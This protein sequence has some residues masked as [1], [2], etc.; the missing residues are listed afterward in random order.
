MIP[1]F[2]IIRNVDRSN[3]SILIF[4]PDVQFI[5]KVRTFIKDR[6]MIDNEFFFHRLSMEK[7]VTEKDIFHSQRK[8]KV[9]SF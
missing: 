8:R 5:N 2:D 6:I 3:S 7:Y 9:V 1:I 4:V